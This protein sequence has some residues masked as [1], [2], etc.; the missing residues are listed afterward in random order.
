[1]S[2][3]LDSEGAELDDFPEPPT[4]IKNEEIHIYIDER[5]EVHRFEVG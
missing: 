2:E 4:L 5:G 3:N 1:M